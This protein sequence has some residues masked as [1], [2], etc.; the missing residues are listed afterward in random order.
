M[1]EGDVNA[2]LTTMHQQFSEFSGI[3]RDILKV[4]A[5]IMAVDVVSDGHA[6]IL[7]A[8]LSSIGIGAGP[9]V[10]GLT[11]AAVAGVVA[12]GYL[13]HTAVQGVRHHDGRVST[14]ASSMLQSFPDQ[15]IAHFAE[16]YEWLMDTVRDHLNQGLRRRYAL[17]RRLMDEDRL[18][19]ALADVRVFRQD[20]LSHL[21]QS[22]HTL[23]LFDQRAA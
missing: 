15:H 12:I 5:A 10:A 20:L 7:N 2:A 1:P 22:G 3:S 18:Q 9:A 4:I 23:A 8:L 13:A 19:K 21:A 16:H 6:D 11:G 17:D 14:L